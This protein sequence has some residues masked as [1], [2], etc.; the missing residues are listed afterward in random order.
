MH[1]S[2]PLFESEVLRTQK[3]V[4]R[5][6]DVASLRGKQ[7]W[8]EENRGPLCC[9]SPS[10][11][12][13]RHWN[14]RLAFRSQLVL[15]T[16]NK[17]SVSEPISPLGYFPDTP[18]GTESFQSVDSAGTKYK[19]LHFNYNGQCVHS[20][21]ELVFDTK[22]ANE[23]ECEYKN[24]NTGYSRFHY[25]AKGSGTDG[26]CALSFPIE[27]D[28]GRTHSLT[29]IA[30]EIE[31]LRQERSG[32]SVDVVKTKTDI[33]YVQNRGV[34]LTNTEHNN[35]RRA[36]RKINSSLNDE[37]SLEERW[38]Q[39][40]QNNTGLRRYRGTHQYLKPPHRDRTWSDHEAYFHKV[41][42]GRST[43]KKS[44]SN[45]KF[46]QFFQCLS[47][48]GDQKTL[49]RELQEQ[50]LRLLT[51]ATML[52]DHSNN[53]HVSILQE[54]YQIYTG[55]L[56]ENIESTGQHWKELGFLGTDPALELGSGGILTLMFL[57]YFHKKDPVTANAIFQETRRE[58]GGGSGLY[59]FASMCVTVTNWVLTMIQKG[60]LNTIAREM[61][62][63]KLEWINNKEERLILA[64]KKLFTGLMYKIHWNVTRRDGGIFNFLKVSEQ[65]QREMKKD[66][67]I[68]VRI[69]D[70]PDIL[71]LGEHLF[72]RLTRFQQVKQTI[73]LTFTCLHPKALS[74]NEEYSHSY[75]D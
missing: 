21:T 18:L 19:Y 27:H 52:F 2:N 45:V 29:Q 7:S 4:S 5:S 62:V 37:P 14:T 64:A 31:L 41:D 46:G 38:A 28:S 12:D 23:G 65:V 17:D 59:S 56:G 70:L 30:N 8:D 13:Q 61:Q 53:R 48:G 26:D 20:I 51:L 35:V 33:A 72:R 60:K 58:S 67:E 74:S 57:L 11:F 25:Q 47:T 42:I 44:K 73:K 43:K 9:D 75:P 71:Y 24:V 6:F 69:A 34:V 36:K 39:E 63:S 3:L 49:T 32:D 22:E 50:R 1:T 55:K 15:Q 16:T 40:S 68:V 10:S 66:V 54:I